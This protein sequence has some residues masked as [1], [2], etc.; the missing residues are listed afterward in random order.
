MIV[1]EI[2]KADLVGFGSPAY[3][4]NMFAPMLS[5][6]KI[7]KEESKRTTFLCKTFFYL[8]YGGI[9]SGKAFLINARLFN[10]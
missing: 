1:E 7:M 3:H 8:N 5:L 10:E 6:F 9:T 2:K 4:M